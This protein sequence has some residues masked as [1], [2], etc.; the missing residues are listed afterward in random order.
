[1]NTASA[2]A[3]VDEKVNQSESQQTRL[4]DYV[5][6]LELYTNSY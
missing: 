6:K 4:C 5:P 2:T 1:M 3:K